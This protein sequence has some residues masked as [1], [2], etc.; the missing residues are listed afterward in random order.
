LLHY[1]MPLQK[2]KFQMLKVLVHQVVALSMV[3]DTL[4]LLEVIIIKRAVSHNIQDM[5][6]LLVMLMDGNL[7]LQV[8]LY[9]LIQMQKQEKELN[10]KRAK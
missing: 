6:Q 4:T 9:T 1:T 2:Q 3:I 8:A 10:Y 7:K 5:L